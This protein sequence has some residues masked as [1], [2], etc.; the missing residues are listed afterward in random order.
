[1]LERL[2]EQTN[3]SPDDTHSF[4]LAN[5]R[6]KQNKAFRQILG[7]AATKYTGENKMEYKPW[8]E[9]LERETQGLQLDAYQ[10]LDLLKA[11]TAG[12]A[13]DAIQPSL[14]VQQESSPD[15]ALTMA[16][17]ALDK[18]FFTVQ[19]P[20]QQLIQQLLH[21]PTVNSDEPGALSTFAEVC[22]AIVFLKSQNQT[23]FASLDE[24]STK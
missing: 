16:W 20:S 9:A 5:Y 10:K 14:L 12:E 4:H 1:M 19:R 22:E 11:R 24:C 15:R 3:I 2:P 23:A 8:K 13:H 6:M 17:S 18:R 21:G 7:A